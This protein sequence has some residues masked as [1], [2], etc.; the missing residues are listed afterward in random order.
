MATPSQA[1]TTK[2]SAPAKK[3][4]RVLNL[5]AAR[6]QRAAARAEADSQPVTLELGDE[7]FEL[8]VEMPYDLIRLAS[9]GDLHG[10]LASLF[11]GDEDAMKRLYAQRLSMD[12]LEALV[13]GA[14]EIYGVGEGK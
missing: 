4:A 3:P 2:G 10:A 9:E 8:P 6:A 13:K 7:M 14:S 5:N 12:D 1:K 11:D